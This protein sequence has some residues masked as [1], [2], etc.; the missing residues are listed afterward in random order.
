M[1]SD[2]ALRDVILGLS[3]FVV[4]M[5]L[6][7]D[8]RHLIALVVERKTWQVWFV[9]IYAGVAIIVGLI[10]ELLFNAPGVPLTWRTALYVTGLALI[11][12]GMVGVAYSVGRHDK[13][14]TDTKGE[15]DA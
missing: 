4:G 11:F 12:V 13:R 15:A 5:C 6:Y 2:H 3:A 14:S 8:S 1:M 9:M 7:M 10:A